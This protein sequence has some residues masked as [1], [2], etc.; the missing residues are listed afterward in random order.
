M[1]SGAPFFGRAAE[2]ALLS[3]Q[4]A[5]AVLGADLDPAAVATADRLAVHAR[6]GSYLK[7]RYLQGQHATP[8]AFRERYRWDGWGWRWGGNRGRSGP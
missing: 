3:A 6:M 1:G 7:G 4:A 2:L 8:G 5:A